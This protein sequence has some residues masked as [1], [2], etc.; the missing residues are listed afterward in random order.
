MK[1]VNVKLTKPLQSSFKIKKICLPVLE[2]NW[3]FH[4]EYE[5]MFMNRSR[6]KRF[7]GDNIAYYED[8]EIF[9]IGPIL[10]HI[11]YSPAMNGG[12]KRHHE[13]FLIQFR[14]DFIG[15]DAHEI[16]ELISVQNLSC[17][18]QC[19]TLKILKNYAI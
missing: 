14:N 18:P 7:I 9:F 8:G 6:G 16:P 11:W 17:F 5:I 2:F 19:N 15:L 12:E 1:P 10:P 4:S 3:H 13:A